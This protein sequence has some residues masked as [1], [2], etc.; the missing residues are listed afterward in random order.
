MGIS[1]CNPIIL[2]SLCRVYERRSAFEKRSRQGMGFRE[3]CTH[4]R[5]AGGSR[6]TRT[7]PPAS[8]FALVFFS[9][10]ISALAHWSGALGSHHGKSLGDNGMVLRSTTIVVRDAVE[11]SGATD[12]TAPWWILCSMRG[13]V[14]SIELNAESLAANYTAA[15]ARKVGRKEGRKELAVVRPRWS[16]RTGY[17]SILWFG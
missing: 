2:A 10:R 12:S 13:V 11:R 9:G 1:F 14:C 5:A 7:P 6:R 8:V 17:V 15:I 3:N 4:S 16:V